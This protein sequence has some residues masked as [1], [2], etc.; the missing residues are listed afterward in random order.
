[1]ELIKPGVNINFVGNRNYAY[2]FS[3]ILAVLALVSI[4]IKGQVKLGIDFSGGAAIQVKF[5]KSVDTKEI[6]LALE[7]LGENLV[8]QKF[9][10]AGEEFMIR[11]DLPE[12]GAEGLTKKVKDL[13]EAR[14]GRGNVEIRG[15]ETVGPKVGKDLREAAVWAT[16][17]ALGML[18]VY[19]WFRFE[20][21]MALGAIVCL[22]HDVVM[23]YGIWVWMDKEFN[24]TILAAILTIIGFDINDT[25]VVCDRIRENLPIMRGKSLD[26]ILNT[27][28]N[29]TLGRTILTGGATLLVL[30]ALLV[31]GTSVLR[32]FAWA[33]ILGILFGT[34]SSIFVATPLVLAWDRIIPIKRA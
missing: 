22:I 14:V 25:I 1:V 11:A 26:A 8:V 31:F 4:P 21:S 34:Y 3:A 2:L 32:D 15:V 10:M 18:L 20:L 23:I 13:L 7:P 5:N 6:R 17:V 33:M 19:V 16:V 9:A 24:L 27:S 30:I 12:E 29:Q 28:I